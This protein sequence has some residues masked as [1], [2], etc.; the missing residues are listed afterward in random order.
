[1]G[2]AA[3]LELRRGKPVGGCGARH[4]VGLPDRCADGVAGY[5]RGSMIAR[6]P[7]GLVPS[8]ASVRWLATEPDSPARVCFP[9]RNAAV[10]GYQLRTTLAGRDISVRADPGLHPGLMELAL[11]AEIAGGL[12]EGSMQGVADPLHVELVLDE[13]A[14]GPLCVCVCPEVTF[15]GS[16]RARIPF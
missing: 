9:F 14:E 13:A 4:L 7:D 3:N 8:E 15:V 6:L 5:A 12:S 16:R 1:M 11:Q 10:N 2:V